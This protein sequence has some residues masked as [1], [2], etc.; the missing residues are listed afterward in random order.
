MNTVAASA[1]IRRSAGDKNQRRDERFPGRGASVRAFW[2]ES[3]GKMKSDFARVL[4]VS[5]RGVALELSGNPLRNSTIRIEGERIGVKGTATIRHIWR[6]GA[7]YVVG[8]EMDKVMAWKEPVPAA[9]PP[10]KPESFDPDDCWRWS[11]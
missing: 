10:K 5:R 2:L 9:V 6:S 7:K 11:D 8:A 3:D 1:R 4:N